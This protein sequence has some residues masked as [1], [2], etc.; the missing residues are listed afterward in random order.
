MFALSNKSQSVSPNDQ[1]RLSSTIDKV[2][3]KRST[4]VLLLLLSGKWDNDQACI[5][6]NIVQNFHECTL[7]LFS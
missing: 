4:G 3:S 2:A 5:C 7:F 6:E 1:S